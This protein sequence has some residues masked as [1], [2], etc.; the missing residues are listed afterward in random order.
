V[1]G[2]THASYLKPHAFYSSLRCEQQSAPPMTFFIEKRLALGAIR[3]GVSTPRDNTPDDGPR[4][5]ST[6]PS[7]EYIRRRGS[8]H[9]F[10]DRDR[11]DAPSLPI[12]RTISA[13]SFWSSLKPDG[14]PRGYA[15][16]ALMLFGP[17]FALLGLAVIVRKGAQGW[18]EVILGLIMVA[19]PV[20]MTAQHRKQIRQQE[21]RQRSEREATEARN[22]QMLVAYMAAL[23]RARTQGDDSALAE[24]ARESEAL[25]LPYD[26]WAPAARRTALLIAFD[27]LAHREIAATNDVANAVTRAAGLTAED[28]MAVKVDLY[29]TVVWH[30]LADDRLPDDQHLAVLRQGLGI[31]EVP[32]EAKAEA[33]FRRIHGLDTERL[34]RE[35]CTT[36]LGFGEYCL[37]QTASD[38]GALHVTNKRIIVQRKRP[39]EAPL[40][41]VSDVSVQVDDS[42][43]SFRTDDPKKPLRL[44]V[45]DPIYTAAI[46]DIAARIDERPRGFA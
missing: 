5:L 31:D 38:Q 4:E 7:G 6:G 36:Q 42:T 3:F 2:G 37:Y 46:I 26:L 8:G 45:G 15:F 23:E 17:L 20:I 19:I 16:L 24:L 35:R 39:F 1:E 34:T 22:R 21:E 11:F 41:L 40:V 12:A 32:Q 13:T 28:A 14:T 44:R 18:I 30:L 27:A 29:R 33:E 9:F 43:V 25:T 10:E